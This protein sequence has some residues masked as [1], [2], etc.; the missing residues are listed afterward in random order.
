MGFWSFKITDQKQHPDK[1][2]KEYVYDNRHSMRVEEGDEFIYEKKSGQSRLQFVGTGKVS[3]VRT[4][5]PKPE[6]RL[7]GRVNCIYTAVL[8]NYRPFPKEIDISY[9]KSGRRTRASLGIEN[10]NQV[11]LSRSVAKLSQGLFFRITEEGRGL[12]EHMASSPPLISTTAFGVAYQEANTSIT[13]SDPDPFSNDP[14]I[15]ERGVKAHRVVQNQLAS[16]LSGV[17]IAPRSPGSL[18]PDFD[19][20]WQQGELTF[21]AEVKSLTAANEEK[22]L[23]L[24]LG[25]V[26]W[27]AHKLGGSPQV[28]GVLVAERQPA[29]PSWE[30]LCADVGIILAWPEVFASR[31]Q[32]V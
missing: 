10:L 2:G 22:Q 12:V 5:S 9:S 1:F 17:G 19:I 4:R 31:L 25:Q 30:S 20:G 27:Y 3:A 14:A 32:S 16:H 6:E 7:G 18:E 28:K 29:D 13:L 24:G 8:A 23:R 26:L 15:I 21:V 11:G